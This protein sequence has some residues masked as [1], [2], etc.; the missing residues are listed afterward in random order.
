MAGDNAHTSANSLDWAGI[1]KGIL[2]CADC[3]GI[4]T[5]IF[6]NADTTY[7]S[8]TTYLGKTDH[9]YTQAG[10]FIWDGYGAMITTIPAD[11]AEGQQYIVSENRITHVDKLG[12]V[13]TG[14]SAARYILH[15]VAPNLL[16]RRWTLVELEGQPVSVSDANS[17]QPYFAMQ[18]PDDSFSGHAGCNQFSGTFTLEAGNRILFSKIMATKKACPDLALVSRFL[19]VLEMTDNYN[20]NGDELILNKAK[21]A[22]LARFRAPTLQ[23][24]K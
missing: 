21:M 18:A 10:A 6:L 12:Q 3:E 24:G 15:K 7:S 13:I 11:G 14:E 16:G 8:M 4:R 23:P 5:T 22:P 19:K 2:P 9:L 1:Y 17:M 20:L